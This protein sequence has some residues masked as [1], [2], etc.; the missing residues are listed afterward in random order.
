MPEKPPHEDEVDE[1]DVVS[2]GSETESESEEDEDTVSYFDLV[3]KVL[4]FDKFDFSV[5]PGVDGESKPIA[6]YDQFVFTSSHTR[7]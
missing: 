7:D 1:D 4:G 6:L 5:I 3:R 2:S